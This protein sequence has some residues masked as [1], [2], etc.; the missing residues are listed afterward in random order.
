MY[1]LYLEGT[2][3]RVIISKDIIKEWKKQAVSLDTVKETNQ[4]V[5]PEFK[6]LTLFK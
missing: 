5:I 3:P 4:Q 1:W 6:C 2:N